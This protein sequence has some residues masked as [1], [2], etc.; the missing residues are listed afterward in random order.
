MELL[1][2]KYRPKWFGRIMQVYNTNIPNIVAFGEAIGGKRKAGIP[3]KNW[4][5]FLKEYLKV[6]GTCYDKACQLS[7]ENEEWIKFLEEQTIFQFT[8]RKKENEIGE[9]R[10]AK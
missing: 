7:R 8:G 6:Y 5:S 10:Q 1:I 3:L 4:K 2:R 9:R